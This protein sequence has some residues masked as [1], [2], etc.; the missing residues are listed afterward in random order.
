[1]SPLLFMCVSFIE[2]LIRI[3]YSASGRRIQRVQFSNHRK[4]LSL[5]FPFDV[6]RRTSTHR[7]SFYF[8][9]HTGQG[10]ERDESGSS[11]LDLY[12]YSRPLS[13]PGGPGSVGRE[14]FENVFG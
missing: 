4:T 10:F 13:P 7:T 11:S 12:G 14:G 3:G 6:S 8:V 2:R 9:L 1:M 5:P